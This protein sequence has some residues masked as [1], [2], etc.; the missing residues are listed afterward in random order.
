MSDTGCVRRVLGTIQ[1]STGY[2]DN[3]VDKTLKGK[4]TTVLLNQYLKTK[5]QNH[6][7]N[8]VGAA[9]TVNGIPIFLQLP[10]V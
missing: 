1:V 4:L 2:R 5:E 7:T 9:C 3:E 10:N 8:H 6:Q